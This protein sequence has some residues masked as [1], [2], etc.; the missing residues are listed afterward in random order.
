MR[1]VI[2]RHL[3]I[4]FA[5]AQSVTHALQPVEQVNVQRVIDRWAAAQQPAVEPIGYIAGDGFFGDDA[6]GKAL[7]VDRRVQAPVERE[8]L[9]CGVRETFDG[10]ARGLFLLHRDGVPVVVAFRSVRSPFDL[11]G[12]EGLDVPVGVAAEV[13]RRDGV[14]AL[15]ALFVRT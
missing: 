1:S 8:P 13:L 2:E 10:V 9:E 4:E 6:L 7:V 3:T 11:P 5:L 14:E 12:L 15:A